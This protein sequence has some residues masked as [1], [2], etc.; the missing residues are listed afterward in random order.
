[1]I[2]GGATA[3]LAAACGGGGGDDESSETTAE[4]DQTTTPEL[5]LAAGFASGDRT[6]AVIAAGLEQR[7][8][9]TV[10]DVSEG[11]VN[12]LRDGLPATLPMTLHWHIH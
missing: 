11:F 10:A 7:T 8:M 4:A 6:P 1:M 5:I 12:P 3:A 9:F 2:L